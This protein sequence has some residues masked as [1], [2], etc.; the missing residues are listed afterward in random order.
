MCYCALLNMLRRQISYKVSLLK[1]THKRNTKE[2]MDLFLEVIDMFTNLVVVMTWWCMHISK[3]I[4]MYRLNVCN[5]LFINL[6]KAKK[7]LKIFF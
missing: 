3:L 1:I 4:K 5:F 6:N 7:F 2:H